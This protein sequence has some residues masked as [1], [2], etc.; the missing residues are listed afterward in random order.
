ML[1]HL[2]VL[3]LF[4]NVFSVACRYDNTTAINE[5]GL[6]ESASIKQ[7]FSSYELH[8]PGSIRFAGPFHSAYDLF[9][10]P[11]IRLVEWCSE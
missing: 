11:S 1:A 10:M 3:F 6:S 4:R 8:R 5:D 7:L 9:G 2:L